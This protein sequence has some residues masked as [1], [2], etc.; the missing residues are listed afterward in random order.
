MQ[1]DVG[2]TAVLE[3]KAALDN[4]VDGLRAYFAEMIIVTTIVL[5]IIL[6]YFIDY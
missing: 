1:K 6:K 2:S 5:I 3:V 4:K